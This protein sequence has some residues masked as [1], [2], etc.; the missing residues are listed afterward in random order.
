MALSERG[1]AQAE[2]LGAAFADEKVD[3]VV[4]SA[5][6]RTKET[7]AAVLKRHPSVPT[8]RVAGL[9]EISWGVWEGGTSTPGLQTLWKIWED[10]N[11]YA[12]APNGESPIDVEE[13][14]TPEIYKLLERPETDIVIVAHGRLLRVLLASLLFQDLTYMEAFTHTN[15]CVNIIDCAVSSAPEKDHAALE[16]FAKSGINV[17]RRERTKDD[18][19]L[20]PDTSGA[21]EKGGPPGFTAAD[22]IMGDG[23]KDKAS[24]KIAHATNIGFKVT[25]MNDSTH[26]TP[27]LRSRRWN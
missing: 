14:S 17:T 25:M 7:A 8:L 23:R 18:N 13:R 27:E 4:H 12:K 22:I 1:R 26:L 20:A 11:F 5:L 10:G 9:D 16:E 2:A 3:L 19:I 24:P 6:Q 21:D 15:T